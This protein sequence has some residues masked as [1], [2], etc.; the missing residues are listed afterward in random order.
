MRHLHFFKPLH[1]KPHN[2]HRNKQLTQFIAIPEL[3]KQRR[4][5][6]LNHFED[7]LELLSKENMPFL[8]KV[9]KY[10]LFQ[11]IVTDLYLLSKKKNLE[12]IDII[13]IAFLIGNSLLI[14]HVLHIHNSALNRN[15]QQK[16]I[17]C[18]NIHS[19]NYLA[20]KG[21][22]INISTMI[23]ATETG[24]LTVLK[25]C[26]SRGIY[27]NKDTL[28]DAAIYGDMGVLK[29]L[30]QE[31]NIKPDRTTLDNTILGSG[32]TNHRNREATDYIYNLVY[33]EPRNNHNKFCHR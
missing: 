7:Q 15:L 27:P 10:I 12:K 21:I 3:S 14:D 32:L 20:T 17:L 33:R 24:C 23:Y 9:G 1:S 26:V 22:P 30:I 5:L 25:Y 8:N 6:L 28:D 13:D 31:R 29:Y 4:K 16:A 18:S 11:Q 2:A 19:L